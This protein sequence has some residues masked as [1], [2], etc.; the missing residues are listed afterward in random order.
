MKK[1]YSHL[2]DIV[3]KDEDE[4]KQMIRLIKESSLSDEIKSF[5][6]KC[7]E[8]ALWFPLFL[9]KKNVSLHRL[10]TMIFGKGYNKKTD[11]GGDDPDQ[12][13]DLSKSDAQSLKSTAV[14]E[15]KQPSLE[16]TLS[17]SNDP[18]E[19]E[20]MAQSGDLIPME[21]QST[22]KGHGRMPHTVYQ[23]CVEVQLLL[24]LM[25]GDDCPTLCGGK[26]GE[27][28]AGVI[29]R[30]KGQN[31]AQIYRYTVDKLRCNL[32][33]IIIKADIPPEVGTEKYD[34]SFKAIVALMK[35]YMAMPFYRQE[36]FQRLLGF[37]LPDST[38]WDLIEQLAGYCYAPFNH[39]KF[40]AANGEVIQNDDT[41]LKILEVIKQIKEGTAGDRT[42]M[43]TTGIVATYQEK[44][45][46]IFMNG[47][48]H[49]GENVGDILKRR[50]A[51]KEPIIQMCDALSSN[52][53]KTMQT[54]LC[55]CL[56]H[57]FRKFEERVNFFEPECLFIM[58]KLSDVFEIDAKVCD[59]NQQDR[60]TY[61]QQ[62]SKPI[63]D[64]LAQFMATLINE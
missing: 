40:L 64:E 53:P 34:E 52:I 48:Q 28:K 29:I 60:L 51:E 18:V 57:G 20:P 22:Q 35:Y 33:G 13:P 11:K 25:A 63:M 49:S 19:V 61:H 23:N 3:D 54:I 42:G 10:R 59:M 6:I 41:S 30:V 50:A 36:N 38:Q 4:I 1:Q 56:S 21:K 12:A 62:H 27:Y 45:I 17:V 44:K 37:P 32:C 26:L 2:P 31:F 7:I 8:L 16:E 58:K 47:R 43:Y 5:A 24:N 14:S 9:Q 15:E 46:A 39:L 55:N